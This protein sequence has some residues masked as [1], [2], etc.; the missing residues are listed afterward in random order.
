MERIFDDYQNRLHAGMA[1]LL[2]RY[3]AKTPKVPQHDM[4]MMRQHGTLFPTY[5]AM[6]PMR[7]P[8]P[9]ALSPALDNVAHKFTPPAITVAMP[10]AQAPQDLLQVPPDLLQVPPDL[11]QVPQDI[12]SEVGQRSD[13]V[14]N[15]AMWVLVLLLLV[16]LG[17]VIYVTVSSFRSQ[18]VS[19]NDGTHRQPVVGPPAI[20]SRDSNAMS[21]DLG[22]TL[23]NQN[24]MEHELAQEEDLDLDDL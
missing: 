11:L 2:E 14:I 23:G 10:N 4:M 6:E 7:I 8:S 3:G 21:P 5:S 22:H 9:V 19:V 24:I 12:Q 13:W 20:I 1:N 15:L 18:N 17:F 16:V